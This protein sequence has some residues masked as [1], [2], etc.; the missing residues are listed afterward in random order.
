VSAFALA[1]PEA[2]HLLPL[3][4]ATGRAG[5]VYLCHPFLVHA[6]QRH[7]AR[8]HGPRFVAQPPVPWRPGVDGFPAEP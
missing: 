1:I 8:R 2:V 7:R 4:L 6:A 5:D 3:A